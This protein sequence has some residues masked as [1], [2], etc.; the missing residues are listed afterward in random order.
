[1][2]DHAIRGDVGRIHKVLDAGRHAEQPHERG[3]QHK[4]KRP[5]CLVRTSFCRFFR[6]QA[7]PFG[8]C[9]ARRGRQQSHTNTRVHTRRDISFEC[10]RGHRPPL[11]RERLGAM[12]TCEN[13][14]GTD[15]DFDTSRGDAVCIQCGTVLEE[16]TIVN[17]AVSYTH[18]TLPT[19]A[20]V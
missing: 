13:C 8:R 10:A 2:H 5:R 20:I 19:T 6:E 9:E 15:I 16:N 7:R 4:K 17:E 1:M 3:A 11:L 14:G 18:L 12:P